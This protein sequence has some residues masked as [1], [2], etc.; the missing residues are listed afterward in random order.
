MDDSRIEPLEPLGVYE[1]LRDVSTR[2]ERICF[3]FGAGASAGYSR[4]AAQLSPPVVV[5]LF[6]DS[7]PVVKEVIQRTTHETILRR[8][9][10]MVEALVEHGGDLEAYLGHLFRLNRDNELFTKLMLYLQDVCLAASLGIDQNERSNNYLRLIYRM[11]SL[12]GSKWSCITFN[13]DTI[14]E[15]SFLAAGSD[16]R[17]FSKVAEYQQDPKIIKIHGGVNLRYHINERAKPDR[18]IFRLMLSFPAD[19]PIGDVGMLP[20]ASG[21]EAPPV[22]SHNTVARHQAPGH[23]RMSDYDFPLMMVPIHNANDEHSKFFQERVDEA[24]AEISRSSLVI[25]VGYNF[26]DKI[27]VEKIKEIENTKKSLL[28]VSGSDFSSDPAGYPGYS[29]ITS[30]WKGRIYFFKG[31]KF[32]GFTDCIGPA[33]PIP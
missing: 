5:T 15:K 33:K 2:D 9:E 4:I 6:D 22:A 29:A 1:L 3:I 23:E 11:E 16:A 28:I 13:Y 18:E 10:N 20:L 12:R 7:N 24:V 30:I 31:E 17:T 27:F 19:P 14:L 26:G 8:R 21:A 32:T 25:A